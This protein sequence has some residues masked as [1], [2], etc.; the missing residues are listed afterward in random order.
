MYKHDD[1]KREDTL[2]TYEKPQIQ[3]LELE[4]VIRGVD[5]SPTDALSTGNQPLS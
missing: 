2:E 3:V 4:Q 5:G 1:N